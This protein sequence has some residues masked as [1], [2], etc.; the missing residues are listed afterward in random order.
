MFLLQVQPGASTK[1]RQQGCSTEW[2]SNEDKKLYLFVYSLCVP[3]VI[4]PKLRH[5]LIYVQNQGD[6]TTHQFFHLRNMS[7]AFTL[8]NSDWGLSLLTSSTTNNLLTRNIPRDKKHVISLS[9]GAVF[10]FSN[11]YVTASL[12]RGN[13]FCWFQ[14]SLCHSWPRNLLRRLAR[15]F[16][17]IAESG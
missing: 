10:F 16:G 6:K 17:G 2:L 12:L 13:M 7:L 9:E 3:T 4:Q 14:I 1:Q 15:T 11:T 5:P 8:S